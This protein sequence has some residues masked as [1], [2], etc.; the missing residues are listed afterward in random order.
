[1]IAYKWDSYHGS[2]FGRVLKALEIYLIGGILL[3]YIIIFPWWKF[4]KILKHKST[5]LFNKL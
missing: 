3:W 2:K 1:M 5:N 4:E